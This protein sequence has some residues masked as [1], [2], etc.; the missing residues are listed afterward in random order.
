METSLEVLQAF[1]HAYRDLP[2]ICDECGAE[3][4]KRLS[5]L[6]DNARSNRASSG[7]GRDDISWCSDAEKFACDRH[8]EQMRNDPPEGMSWCAEFFKERFPHMFV[9]SLRPSREELNSLLARAKAV[10]VASEPVPA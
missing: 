3:A 1:V 5:Y 7:Y 4:T 9:Q 2:H 8:N 10:I 6:Y